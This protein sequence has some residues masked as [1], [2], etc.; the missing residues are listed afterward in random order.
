MK[1]LEK[2]LVPIDINTDYREHL[3][4]AMKIAQSY[5]SEI[6]M[7]Y[8][9]PEEEL[10][11][12]IKDIVIKVVSESLNDIK[13]TLTNE[14]IQVREPVITFGKPV[15]KINQIAN[16]EKVN[17]ILLGSN[18][19]HKREKFKLGIIS[20]Q[21]IRISDVP[22]WVVK[23]KEETIL[24]NIL[25]PVDFSAPSKR[26]LNNAIL[27]SR[28][29][30]ANLRIL[31]VYEPITYASPKI[32]LDLEKEN[33]SR[34][35]KVK[36]EM[37][38][39]VK[40]FDLNG[41]NH[42][43][44][45]KTGIVHEKILTTI[46]KY[47]HDLLV[48]GTNGR[49][50]LNRFFMGSVTE[51]VVRQIPCSFVTTKTQDI[52]QLK[53]DNEIKEVE[54]HFNNGIELV[55]SGFYEEAINQFMICIQINDMHIPSVYKLAELHTILGDTAKSRYFDNMAKD[56]LTRLWDKKIEMEIRKHY[57]FEK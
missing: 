32:M 55:K 20:E 8:V 54:I 37:N 34:L 46:K 43:I 49:S 21:L 26:A 39:F 29:F 23:T 56:I 51:K 11:D 9:I 3:T 24:T 42:K 1:L 35:K 13:K 5:N 28:K 45:I 38:Q 15:D 18:S 27:L 31:T 22:V 10:H 53:L 25:C 12:D 44:D 41:I 16:S 4:K 7:I 47:G 14:K 36:S 50:G 48:M 19:K 52:I 30:Q 57:R 6:I 33:A 40:E 17:L 2:I